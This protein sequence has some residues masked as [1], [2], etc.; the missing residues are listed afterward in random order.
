VAPQLQSADNDFHDDQD[1]YDQLQ[2]R[3]SLGIDNV[4]KCLG[5]IGDHGELSGQDIRSLL[6]FI[7]VFKPRVKALQSGPLPENVGFFRYGDETGNTMLD[8][9]RVTDVLENCPPPTGR[10]A[11]S[12]RKRPPRFSRHAPE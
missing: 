1:N 5:G 4:G 9:Q 2:P 12:H 8:K 11:R 3:R 10:A 7:F 6:Q